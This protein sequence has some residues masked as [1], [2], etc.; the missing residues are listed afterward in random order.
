[1]I[2]GQFIF[3]LHLQFQQFF[4]ISAVPYNHQH[5]HHNQI[6]NQVQN[7]GGASNQQLNAHQQQ[8]NSNFF[9][10]MQTFGTFTPN[11]MF[12]YDSRMIQNA[13]LAMMSQ[14]QV[15]HSNDELAQPDQL[16]SIEE[17]GQKAQII[18]Y[19]NTNLIENQV[20]NQ[21]GNQVGNQVENQVEN[22][23][24]VSAGG[25]VLANNLVDQAMFM[26]GINN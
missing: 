5:S 19:D 21:V 22:Q 23:G 11:N 8:N 14:P 7:R 20:E 18:E 10:Q 3:P 26:S 9:P 17:N 13:R 12:T 25:R 2:S 1:M 6:N 24:Q 16:I 15:G 4:T